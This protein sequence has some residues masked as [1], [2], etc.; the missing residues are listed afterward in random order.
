MCTMGVTMG[1]ASVGMA[2]SV[3]SVGM[4]F[5]GV[6]TGEGQSVGICFFMYLDK[7]S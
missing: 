1:V 4:G 6:A 3:A 7:R 5:H 2:V